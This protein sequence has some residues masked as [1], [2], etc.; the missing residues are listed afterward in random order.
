MSGRLKW[1]NVNRNLCVSKK[2]KSTVVGSR[3]RG[4]QAVG[5]PL[6]VDFDGKFRSER[7]CP[8]CDVKMPWRSILME[9]LVI[10]AISFRIWFED[11]VV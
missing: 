2:K 8:N 3:E 10:A 6:P 4:G 5:P 11:G 9:W 1:W 7:S